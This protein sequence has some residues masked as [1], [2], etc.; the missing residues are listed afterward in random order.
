MSHSVA[1]NPVRQIAHR[2]RGQ[3]HGP[4]TRLMSPSD[5][6]EILKP[7]VFLDLFDLEGKPFV[8]PLHPHSGIATLAVTVSGRTRNLNIGSA[9]CS[10]QVLTG[11]L[12][13]SRRCDWNPAPSRQIEIR[14]DS[15][16]CGVLEDRSL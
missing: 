3:A 15:L 11:L 12:P 13:A 8:E 16:S 4:L 1:H 6:G 7:F 2:T 9:F 5:F 10:S 14:G